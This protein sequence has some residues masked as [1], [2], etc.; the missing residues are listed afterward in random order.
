M[1]RLFVFILGVLILGFNAYANGSRNQ[2]LQ[3]AML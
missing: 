2:I 3:R 1:K